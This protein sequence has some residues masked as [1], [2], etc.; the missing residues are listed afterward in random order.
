MPLFIF[1]LIV[2]HS[3]GQTQ[4]EDL[5]QII[6]RRSG[7]IRKAQA[8]YKAFEQAALNQTSQNDSSNVPREGIFN[9]YKRWEYH[10][11]PHLDADGNYDFNREAEVTAQY[12]KARANSPKNTTATTANW[13]PLGPYQRTYP[14]YANIGRVECVAFHP[15]NP[16]IFYMGAPSGGVWKTTDNGATWSCLSNTWEQMYVNGIT[17]DPNFPNTVYVI[18]GNNYLYK[19]TDGGTNWSKLFTNY[20]FRNKL[21]IDPTNSNR[22]FATSWGGILRTIDGGLSWTLTYASSYPYP[23][24][25]A[26]KPNDF[27]TIYSTTS[28]AVLKSTDGGF[29]FNQIYSLPSNSVAAN[30]AVTPAAPDNFYVVYVPGIWYGNGYGQFG[31]IYKSTDAGATFTTLA[32]I[33]SPVTIQNGYSCNNCTLGQQAIHQ[34]RYDLTLAVSPTDPNEIWFGT[35]PLF[36]S[37]DGGLTWR[38]EGNGNTS[39]HVDHHTTVFHPTTGKV[40]IGCDGGLYR[41]TRATDTYE[42]MDGFNIS[43]VYRLG[44]LYHVPQKTLYGTQDNGTFK[45]NNNTFTNILGGDGMECFMDYSNTNNLYASTQNGYLYKSLNDGQHWQYIPPN[46]FPSGAKWVT[47]WAMHPTDP[48]T[49]FAGYNAL[50]KSTNGG[51]TWNM[52]GS[53]GTNYSLYDFKIATADPNV[54]YVFGVSGAKK[55]TDGGN[56][57]SSINMPDNLYLFNDL[58]IHPNNA[59]EIWGTSYGKVHRSTNGGQTWQDMSGT[60]PSLSILGILIDKSSSDVYVTTSSGV[61]VRPA[62]SSDWIYFSDGLPKV[63]SQEMEIVAGGGNKLR[64]ATYGRGLWESPVYTPCTPPTAIASVN[65]S[66]VLSATNTAVSLTANAGAGLSYQWYKNNTLIAGATSQNYTATTPGSYAVYVSDGGC[67]QFSNTVEVTTSATLSL[68]SATLCNYTNNNIVFNASGFP[69]GTVFTAQLYVNDGL[70]STN[71]GTSSPISLYVGTASNSTLAIKIMASYFGIEVNS[72]TLAVA[73]ISGAITNSNGMRLYNLPLCSGKTIT[74]YAN[75]YGSNLPNSPLIYQWQKD[76]NDIANETNQTLNV[77]QSG[78]YS[79]KITRGDCPTTTASTGIYNSSSTF[80]SSQVVGHP[81]RCTGQTVK[82]QS[83]YISNTAVYIWRKND[84]VIPNATSYTYNATETG[85]YSVAVND[86][87][88]CTFNSPGNVFVSIGTLPVNITAYD[89]TIRCNNSGTAYL[90]KTYP[91]SYTLPVA[92]ADPI[93]Y[94]WK[95]DGQVIGDNTGQT[96]NA[97]TSG[98]YT[99]SASDSTCRATSNPILIQFTDNIPTTITA[100]GSTDLCQ[101]QNVYLYATNSSG[102]LIW[103]KEGVDISGTFGSGY[104]ASMAGKYRVKRTIGSCVSYSNEITV[105]IN[106]TA[107][108]PMIPPPSS[109]KSCYG[110][111]LSTIYMPGYTYQ[112]RKEGMVLSGNGNFSSYTATQSGNYDVVVSNGTCSG[113]SNTVPVVIGQMDVKISSGSSINSFCSNSI[114]NLT[115]SGGGSTIQWRRNGIDIPNATGY[116]YNAAMA[117]NYTVYSSQGGCSGESAP[118]IIKVGRPA[119]GIMPNTTVN[120]GNTTTLTAIFEG[121]GPWIFTLND[122]VKRYANTSPFTFTVSP[123]QTTTYSLVSV[124]NGCQDCPVHYTITNPLAGIDTYQASQHLTLKGPLNSN[125]NILVGAYK[126]V[127]FEPGFSATDVT[128]F[129]ANNVGCEPSALNTAIP[130][131]PIPPTYTYE[132]IGVEKK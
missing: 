44:G 17:I 11:R 120:G 87:E 127:V 80:V 3:F 48:N 56:N 31:A 96:L 16:N 90:Y 68:V 82:V 116:S 13:Q 84:V 130:K 40:Y 5:S 101:G 1:F 104:T 81:Y 117:G 20:S 126:S 115:T 69:P 119:T 57:W 129:T 93:T 128:S 98:V 39:V 24:D 29:T 95:K 58:A 65:G 10:I 106:P 19:S 72:S 41:Y 67:V 61:F 118:F 49:L 102:T 12:L 131:I 114:I 2:F 50:Y 6:T 37:T 23:E 88:N 38:Q 121:L 36:S 83:S 112:W 30:I 4:V 113:I 73:T 122:G 21:I 60:L 123:S 74:L 89:D 70:Y 14:G 124:R 27:N 43:Q 63:D 15:T 22:M 97:N 28:T 62:S 34:G 54:I 109:S 108:V 52:I 18:T 45:L 78:N 105:T 66:S 9:L 94:Q 53:L 91:Y 46:P 8:A 100:S 59:S 51:S 32:D 47:P 7:N 42:I 79:A 55:T 86:G 35:V 103:Q 85:N 33:N 107:F 92:S 132:G 110:V 75:S 111:S 125:S 77:S 26:F 64:V 71:A 25:I 99:L 76:G